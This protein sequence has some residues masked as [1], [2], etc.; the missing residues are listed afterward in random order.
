MIYHH[1]TKA[2]FRLQRKEDRKE[3][4]HNFV[5]INKHLI[6]KLESLL[7]KTDTVITE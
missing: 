4:T 6:E 7:N 1:L 3:Y 2:D 5:A